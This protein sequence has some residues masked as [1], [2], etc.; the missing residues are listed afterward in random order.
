MNED[1]SSTKYLRIL[2]RQPDTGMYIQ[3]SGEWGAERNSA[4]DFDSSLLA[5][6][7]AKEN[8]FLGSAVLM[9]VG[10]EQF[11]TVLA[12]VQRP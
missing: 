6:E 10:P 11:D 2:L 7:W 9:A 1:Q 5:Y 12:R 4:R 8:G 3:S